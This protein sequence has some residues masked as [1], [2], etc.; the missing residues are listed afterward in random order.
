MTAPAAMPS[1]AQTAVKPR[2]ESHSPCRLRFASGLCR[3]AAGGREQKFDRFN[4]VSARTGLPEG[5]PA[6]NVVTRRA[7]RKRQERHPRCRRSGLAFA[8]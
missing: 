2:K 7:L 6:V 4:G 8:A 1:T 3:K 5:K